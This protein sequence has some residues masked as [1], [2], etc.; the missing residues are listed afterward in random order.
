MGELVSLLKTEEFLRKSQL[1]MKH[2]READLV[3]IDNLMYMT[4]DQNEANL[5]SDLI[6]HLYE[7]VL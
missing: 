7:Q 2:I 4:M 1:K 3:I 6:N 5:F